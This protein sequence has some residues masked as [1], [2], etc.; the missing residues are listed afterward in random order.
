[1]PTKV[2]IHMDNAHFTYK[3]HQDNVCQMVLKLKI[4]E[5]TLR[6]AH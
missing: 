3:M 6:F 4:V 5:D 1:M 2:L